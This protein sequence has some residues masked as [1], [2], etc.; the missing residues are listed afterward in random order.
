MGYHISCLGIALKTGLPAHLLRP[1]ERF[2]STFRD[3]FKTGVNRRY[4]SVEVIKD[5][6][7]ES[8]RDVV[9]E[10]SAPNFVSPA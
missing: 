8:Q 3:L 5:F 10:N 6:A 4:Q 9:V 2:D 1:F 7:E